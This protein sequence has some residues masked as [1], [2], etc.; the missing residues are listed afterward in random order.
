MQPAKKKVDRKTNSSNLR[1]PSSRVIKSAGNTPSS[2][3]ILNRKSTP[4]ASL[5]LLP[6][7]PNQQQN[8]TID[9]LDA[10][11]IESID[12]LNVT[13]AS[14]NG[15]DNSHGTTPSKPIDGLKKCPCNNSSP[16]STYIKCAKCS[17][18]WHNKCC[19]LVGI[20]QGAIKKLVQWQCPQCYVC[21]FFGNKTMGTN[22]KSFN[23]AML[24]MEE[25]T[26]ELN[27]NITKIDF[28]NQHIK[29]L[30]LDD[31]KFK[32]QTSKIDRL[33]TDMEELNGWYS[34]KTS[35]SLPCFSLQPFLI[36]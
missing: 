14:D 30:L 36:D 12:S 34:G 15:S 27:D 13:A 1:P 26:E 6:Q 4:C 17:Q 16:D 8:Y 5:N 24:H 18:E 20:T 32:A 28:F 3:P 23:S 31:Q 9:V 25:C 35:Y 11:N 21:P 19:N 29:H 10:D 33:G 7:S 2:S 22:H